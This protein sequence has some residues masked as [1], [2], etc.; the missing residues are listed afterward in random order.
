[1]SPSL[2]CIAVRPYLE[3]FADGELRGDLLRRVSAH[4]EACAACGGVVD[5]VR[6]LGGLLR[7]GRS[8][9][10]DLPDLAGLADGIVSR[11]RAEERESWRG[12][13]ERATDDLHWVLVG[14]GSIAAAFCSVLLVS[15]VMHASVEQRTDSLAAML[16]TMS[17]APPVL[18]QAT[19]VPANIVGSGGSDD[20]EFANLT[21]VNRA[22]HV[23]SLEPLS[24]GNEISASDAQLLVNQ[25]RGL[26]FTQQT[27]RSMTD[28]DAR[29]F[30]WLYSA[31][32]VRPKKVL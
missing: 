6:D 31:T 7:G 1:M 25:L 23:M 24:L 26:R 29:R 10:A 14:A 18:G 28:P 11:I 9:D 12:K 21:E 32:E 30:I 3:S 16:N 2:S 13:F 27:G 15:V 4:I 20:V 5:G 19:V 8:V 22:G 17:V